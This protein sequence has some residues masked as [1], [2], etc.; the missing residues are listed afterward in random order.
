M[1]KVKTL[2]TKRWESDHRKVWEAAIKYRAGVEGI[3][4]HGAV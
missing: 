3:D 1:L 2:E 4:R